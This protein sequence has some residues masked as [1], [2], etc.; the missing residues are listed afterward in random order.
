[1][2]ENSE[3]SSPT[4]SPSDQEDEAIVLPSQFDLRTCGDIADALN[5][6]SGTVQ[7]RADEVEVMTSPG[8]QVLLAAVRDGTRCLEFVAPSKDFLDCMALLGCTPTDFGDQL[9]AAA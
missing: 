6:R 1:M 4:D 9:E 3:S 5:F 8:L 7:I 2:S